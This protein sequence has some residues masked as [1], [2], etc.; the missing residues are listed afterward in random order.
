MAAAVLAKR[1]GVSPTTVGTPAFDEAITAGTV[2]WAVLEDGTLVVQPKFV[3]G[4]EISHSVLSRGAPVRAAGEA[5]IAGSADG[6]YFGLDINDR[7]GHFFQSGWDVLQ[8]GKDAFNA[9]G[10]HF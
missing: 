9:A 7:S 8:I 2:K 5:D 6:G 4:V 1:L 3:D 10:V